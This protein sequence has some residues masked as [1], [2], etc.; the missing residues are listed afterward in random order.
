MRQALNVFVLYSYCI[1]TGPG[2]LSARWQFLKKVF[3]TIVAEGGR[4]VGWQQQQRTD[5]SH[6]RQ[7]KME[8][9]SIRGEN[10]HFAHDILPLCLH[11]KKEGRRK[12]VHVLT[13][14]GIRAQLQ[15]RSQLRKEVGCEKRRLFNVG[16]AREGERKML[17]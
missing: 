9:E 17:F 7:K 10:Q 15:M 5:G 1:E 2:L 12:A 14:L 6:G 16:G 3:N 8:I 11:S 13:P 4:L